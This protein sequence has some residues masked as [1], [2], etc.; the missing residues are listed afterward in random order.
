MTEATR[1]PR[2]VADLFNELMGTHQEKFPEAGKRKA[3]AAPGSRGVYVI[4]DPSGCV[5]HVGRTPSGKGGIAQRLQNHLNSASSFTE[6]YPPLKGNGSKLRDGYTFRCLPVPNDR[7]RALLEAYAIG[8]LCPAHIGL[9]Q[10]VA[11]A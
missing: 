9:H 2:E 4:Y 5:V 1:E 3:L 11:E 10:P 6:K 8:H 7:I